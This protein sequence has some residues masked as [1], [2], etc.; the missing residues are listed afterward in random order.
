MSQ[1]MLGALP[2]AA[3]PLVIYLLFRWR[4]RDVEW[5]SMYVLRRVLETKSRLKAWMQYL[6]VALRT[7]AVAAV[8]LA[9]A[10]PM[11]RR[12]RVGPDA[13]PSPP[14][15]THRIVLLDTSASMAA[16]HEGATRLEAAIGLCRTM[17]RSGIA[18]GRIDI[19]P[20]A[21]RDE[22]ITFTSFPVAPAR[23]EEA[24]TGV[25]APHG[26]ADLAGGLRRAEEM[27]RGTA[28]DRRELFVVSDFAAGNFADTAA[29]DEVVA[30]LARL[31]STGVAIQGLR[32]QAAGTRNFTLAEF[33]PRA[34]TL[35]AG[36]P[37]LFHATVGFSGTAADGETVLTV[38]ADPDTPRAR[39]VHEQPLAMTPGETEIDLAFALPA[40]RHRIRASVRPDDLPADDSAARVF[41]AADGVRVILVQDLDGDRGFDDPRSWLDLA[42]APAGKEAARRGDAQADA[43]TAADTKIMVEGKIADQLG[44]ALLDDV[45]AVIVTAGGG[46]EAAVVETLRRFALRGGLVVLAPKPGQDPATFNAAWR[47]IA[48][49][50]LAGPRWPEVDP[51]RYESCAAEDTESPL[52]RELESPAHGN[53]ANP[54]FYNHFMLAPG[55]P[56]EAT[57]TLLALSD[58]DPLLLERRIGRGGVMLWTA[59]LTHEWHSLVVHPGFPVML[60]RLVGLAADRLRFAANVSPGEPLVMPTD[61]SEVKVIRPDGASELVAT[62]AR[63]DRR[64]VRY[65]LTDQSGVYD[66]REDVASEL[67]GVLFTVSDDTRSESDLTPVATALE[68]RLEAA[69][70]AEWQDST[71]AVAAATAATY[72]GES[73]VL[74]VTL[75][76]LAALVGEAAVSRWLL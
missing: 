71:G 32:T 55:P 43:D 67:P 62:V 39:V 30:T 17:I 40:G 42:L 20:L 5:G 1:A 61:V 25:S 59:G 38:E 31:A 75:A 3:I 12:V 14:P 10:G 63:G 73:W 9:V 46:I 41:T 28:S 70:G 53:L 57:A 44:P 19:L 48:P 7:L 45:D 16:R 37:T 18:P 50:T 6:V 68:A 4:R 36:Q 13:F 21:G 60:L 72:P 58:G 66:I 56:P 2:L 76:M 27:F 11:G 24:L 64:F 74:P 49:A 23:I 35:L 65:S 51:E 26:T 54:R 33:T 29:T 8:V 22:P 15:A 34:D 52:W 69:A 47:S